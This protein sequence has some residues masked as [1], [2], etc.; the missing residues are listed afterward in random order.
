MR[1]LV[2]QES[3]WIKRNPVQ[4][5]HMLERLSA[6]GHEVLVID[7]PIRWRD[8][9]RGLLASRRVH[10]GVAKVVPEAD[11]TVIRTAAL[12]ISGL[13][14]LGWLATNTLELARA[15]GT[16][17]PDVVVILGLSNGLVALGL[18][19]LAGVPAV[20]HLIDALHT[21]AEPQAIRPIA[22]RVEQAILRGA[23][24]VVATNKAL[25]KYAERMGAR[26]DEIVIIPTG[27]D[28]VRFGPHVDGS[29]IRAEY[30]IQPDD[31]V[32]LF[33]GWLYTFSGLRELA[34]IMSADPGTASGL[35]LLV[36]GDG[37]LMPELRR[38]REERLGD[39]LI[40]AGAQPV[41]RMPQFV[42][43][44]DMCLLPA[45][46]NATMAHVVPAKIYEYLAGGKPVLAS[47][48][49]GLRVEFGDN[50]GIRYVDNAEQ[51]LSVANELAANPLER[52]RL[53]A[54]ARRTVEV[55][56]TWCHVTEQFAQTLRAVQQVQPVAPGVGAA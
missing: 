50:S 30:G 20:V 9:G 43:A 25:G 26:P 22:A 41:E 11:V 34:E 23:D 40:L 51:L 48:L 8:E 36:A 56:G 35:K 52:G 18:A 47:A 17:R 31:R 7:Y 45:H 13:G 38:L 4:Q 39:R 42:A 21:L 16:F 2:V 12:R 54:Q 15:F 24:R 3:D 44:A 55:S 28:T 49:A 10:R 29:T 27:A 53:G 33:I 32:M 14:K 19:K 5:H 1:I 37:D 6:Q 46:R